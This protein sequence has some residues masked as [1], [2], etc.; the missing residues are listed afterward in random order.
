VEPPP[1]MWVGAFD[2]S[3]VTRVAREQAVAIA[4]AGQDSSQAMLAKYQQLATT[5]INDKGDPSC[6]N[7]RTSSLVV[8]ERED[9]GPAH[10]TSEDLMRIWVV[11]GAASR[12]EFWFIHAQS[13][14]QAIA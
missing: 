8:N 10:S 9:L 14:P 11:D 1:P 13:D 12:G 2:V 5:M 4:K 7:S 6:A 3:V